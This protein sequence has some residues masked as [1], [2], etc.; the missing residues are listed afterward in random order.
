MNRLLMERDGEFSYEIWGFSPDSNT[1][2]GV[3]TVSKT[4]TDRY[5]LEV[6][7]D[8]SD[9][10]AFTEESLNKNFPDKGYLFDPEMNQIVQF[11]KSV[12]LETIREY[13]KK[14]VERV[15]TG[16]RSYLTSKTNMVEE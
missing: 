2:I 9:L 3:V 16:W 1:D 15:S 7:E 8:C 11:S 4:N 5:S 13:S 12:S 10:L 6:C 14:L